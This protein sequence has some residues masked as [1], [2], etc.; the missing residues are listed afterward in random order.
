MSR[1]PRSA[2]FDPQR[3]VLARRR[4]RPRSPQPQR[5]PAHEHFA[6]GRPD[7]VARR[8]QLLARAHRLAA[9]QHDLACQM[10]EVRED[11]AVL[12]AVMWPELDRHLVQGLRHTT[13]GGP[14]PLPPPAPNATP[15]RAADLRYAALAILVDAREPLTLFEIHRRLHHRGYVLAG[16][17]PVQQLADALAYE[18][19]N[20]RAHRT[21]RGTY[22]ACELSPHRRRRSRQEFTLDN[23]VDPWTP[24]QGWTESRLQPHPEP[25]PRRRSWR[26][27]PW[28][29][30]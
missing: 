7:I 8:S 28:Q 21:A 14:P 19:E 11:L 20:G 30:E 2:A 10:A 9:A 27:R 25:F 1:P 26:H 4:Q 17:H 5:P 18:H 6:P 23:T 13:H 3:L 16:R 15:L 29:Q 12:R 22:E 24:P